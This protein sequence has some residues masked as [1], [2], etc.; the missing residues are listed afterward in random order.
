[1][2]FWHVGFITIP[3]LNQSA[4]KESMYVGVHACVCDNQSVKKESMHACV[5]ACVR[6]R[7]RDTE[8]TSSKAK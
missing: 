7:V 1:M 4:K 5:H 8:R 3:G 6:D 2:D